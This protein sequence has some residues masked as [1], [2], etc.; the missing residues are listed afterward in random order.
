MQVVHAVYV[1]A[2]ATTWLLNWIV[3]PSDTPDRFEELSLV[4]TASFRVE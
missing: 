2:G 3:P 4:V 1:E